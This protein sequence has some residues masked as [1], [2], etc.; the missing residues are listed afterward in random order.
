MPATAIED[1]QCASEKVRSLF[2]RML[3]SSSTLVTIDS[4][5][6]AGLLES[7]A[8]AN[9]WLG[10]REL[11]DEDERALEKELAEYRQN[12]QRLRQVLPSIQ[13]RLLTEKARL[14][15]ARA[16][17]DSAAAWLQASK[18]TR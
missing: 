11:G 14:E 9:Q 12:L 18:K 6:L 13:G 10:R 2:A 7:M 16:H 3:R 4:Q 5:V 8:R 17:L 1:I 15:H